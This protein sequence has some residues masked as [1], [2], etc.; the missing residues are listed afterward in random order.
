MNLILAGSGYL[1]NAIITISNKYNFNKIIEYSRSKK[2]RHLDTVYHFKKDFDDISLSFDE[3]NEKA[4]II[5]M[6]PPRQDND[7]DTRLNNF[8]DK[9]SE[10]KLEKILYISTSGVYG[11]YNGGIVDEKSPLMPLTGR[12]KRRVRAEESIKNF[13]M[14][15]KNKYIIFRVPGIYGPGRLPIERI[16]KGEPIL[17]NSAAKVTNLIHVD[18]LARLSWSSVR[19]DVVNEVF[20]VSDG[21]PTTSTEYY[22][23]ICNIMGLEK[24]ELIDYNQAKEIFSEKRMSFLN[25]SRILDIK[26]MERYFPNQIKYKNL[27]E[28]IKASI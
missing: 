7:N 10:H 18:D 26:K 13:C 23:K 4:S 19:S 28:G 21:S 6:A 22:L 3:I 17:E 27:D 12:A 25:E 2:E 5:Y 15:T 8:L 16:L 20:N 9:I 24:P 14:A 1:G 11:D